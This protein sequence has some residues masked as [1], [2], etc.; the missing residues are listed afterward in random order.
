MEVVGALSG[1]ADCVS[2]SD[3]SVLWTHGPGKSERSKEVSLMKSNAEKAVE[4]S[5]P[6]DRQSQNKEK[7][8]ELYSTKE[9]TTSLANARIER[10]NS[11]PPFRTGRYVPS[12]GYLYSSLNFG[13][14]VGGGGEQEANLLRRYGEAARDRR[15]GKTRVQST[16]FNG[17]EI[18]RALS[19]EQERCRSV[20]HGSALIPQSV[21]I[22]N[23]DWS[24]ISSGETDLG[25]SGKTDITASTRADLKNSEAR[26][27]R[28]QTVGIG[29]DVGI[30]MDK[31]LAGRNSSNSDGRLYVK[32]KDA[33]RS[34]KL[35]KSASL[36]IDEDNPTTEGNSR[37]LNK[38]SKELLAGKK[39]KCFATN[40]SQSSI[41][42]AQ[43][44][45]L[46]N[47]RSR[48]EGDCIDYKPTK[49][50]PLGASPRDKGPGNSD[51]AAKKLGASSTNGRDSQ[52]SPGRKAVFVGNG[53][54]KVE[55]V[56][57]EMQSSKPTSDGN[58]VTSG[59]FM[60]CSR[61]KPKSDFREK[62]MPPRAGRNG[63][64]DAQN[65][66]QG[67][68]KD[69][70]TRKTN[71]YNVDEFES[72][73]RSKN[74]NKQN[75]S[76]KNH[77]RKDSPTKSRTTNCQGNKVSETLNKQCYDEAKKPNDN[78]TA[79]KERLGGRR[80]SLK[81][82]Q[83]SKTNKETL[84][85]S[86]RKLAFNRRESYSKLLRQKNARNLELCKKL[87]I[88]GKGS[89]LRI[90]NDLS[91]PVVVKIKHVK[92]RRLLK[93]NVAYVKREQNSRFSKDQNENEECVL[94]T[95]TVGSSLVG[96]CVPD[97]TFPE[98]RRVSGK[99]DK[100]RCKALLSCLLPRGNS[101]NRIPMVKRIL[102][103]G[104][105]CSILKRLSVSSA[106][107]LKWSIFDGMVKYF[108]DVILCG[109]IYCSESSFGSS[110]SKLGFSMCTIRTA[111]SLLKENH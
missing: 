51:A 62:M 86:N 19:R 61:T 98:S 4:V 76:N 54:G 49:S 48:E 32:A 104:G 43:N 34:R 16:S 41:K 39:I 3:P 85:E 75:E 52:G 87:S 15:K 14:F 95:V 40:C 9:T 55:C 31:K 27:L 21:V 97:G 63:S 99:S 60:R 111:R 81:K 58:A 72:G 74:N 6:S 28:R 89:S 12:D 25:D 36:G 35:C 102:I 11:R 26:C 13:S 30:T 8:S 29:V 106:K 5:E 37:K 46:G 103:G 92:S 17:N 71:G 66:L 80:C 90:Q 67:K 7:Q 108:R 1:Q 33:S 22:L 69:G 107:K 10:Q 94:F 20:D 82:F 109:L 100:P 93:R 84:A 53:N 24:S 78:D 59:A 91:S 73:S 57:R 64:S 79:T 44:A 65:E 45:K 96:A 47:R 42:K 77:C 70:E 2:R 38:K 88:V 83:E 110:M 101:R 50:D 23:G 68:Q 105:A 56:A 18:K